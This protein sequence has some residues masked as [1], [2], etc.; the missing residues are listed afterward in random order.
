MII[1]R[2][3]FGPINNIAQ[4][5]DHPQV[6]ARELVVEVEHPRAGKIKLVGPAVMYNGHRMPVE[7]P[8]PYLSQHTEEVSP[9]ANYADRLTAHCSGIERIV[10]HRWTHKRPEKQRCDIKEPLLQIFS[11][12]QSAESLYHAFRTR[13]KIL[14]GPSG[15]KLVFSPVT[16]DFLSLTSQSPAEMAQLHLYQGRRLSAISDIGTRRFPLGPAN[17]ISLQLH[18]D[19]FLHLWKLV[20]KEL[21]KISNTFSR[22]TCYRA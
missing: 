5:F 18:D 12:G 14:R 11:R 1:V 22:N 20:S 9:N 3:P 8:P 21:M 2:V 15:F 17:F 13:R 4:T 19:D 10:L 6:K 7:R 16:R